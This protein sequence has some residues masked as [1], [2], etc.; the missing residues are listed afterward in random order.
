MPARKSLSLKE[1]QPVTR[2]LGIELD[3]NIII[4]GDFQSVDCHVLL[5]FVIQ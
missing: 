3:S 4:P 2:Y 1:Q 5:Y